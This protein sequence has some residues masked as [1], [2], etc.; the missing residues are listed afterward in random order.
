MTR[1]AGSTTEKMRLDN[2][3]S[4]LVGTT[5]AIGGSKVISPTG[6]TSRS[7]TLTLNGTSTI[8]VP[9]G[10]ICTMAA[11]GFPGDSAIFSIKAAGG[12]Q[13]CYV[14]AQG[15]A[16]NIGFGTTSNPST[17]TRLNVWISAGNTM[18]IQDVGQGARPIYLTFTAVS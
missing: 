1:D 9:N 15:T 8:T 2:V 10:C 5:S 18:S 11:D 3:G 17:G 7:V 6:F 4:L 16:G 13:G 12:F 14:M